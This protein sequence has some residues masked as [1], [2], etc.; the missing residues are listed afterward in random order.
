MDRIDRAVPRR[1]RPDAAEEANEPRN[2]RSRSTPPVGP[3]LQGSATP[4]Q[5]HLPIH[6]LQEVLPP[7]TAINRLEGSLRPRQAM[8]EPL[9]AN[10]SPLHG[11]ASAPGSAAR[12][13]GAVAHDLPTYT[14]RADQRILDLLPAYA[15]G[16]KI[17]LAIAS[18]GQYLTNDGLA[19]T[20]AADNWMGRLNADQRQAV[21]T[22]VESRKSICPVLSRLASITRDL[23]D[24]SRSLEQAARSAAV[25]LSSLRRVLTDAG[26]LTKFGERHIAGRKPNARRAIENNLI[27][28]ETRR[29]RMGEANQRSTAGGESSTRRPRV[30]PAAGERVVDHNPAREAVNPPAG[31]SAPSE[32]ATA[33]VS[34][35]LRASD[36]R[37]LDGLPAYANG[38]NIQ[39]KS[40]SMYLRNDGLANTPAATQWMDRLDEERQ[41]TV[42][43]AIE[44]RRSIRQVLSCLR[45]ITRDLSDP[46][47]S[48]EQAARRNGADPSNLRRVLTES[49][50]TELGQRHLSGRPMAQKSMQTNLDRRDWRARKMVG[51][52]R[53]GSTARDEASTSSPDLGETTLAASG[54]DVNAIASATTPPSPWFF[55]GLSQWNVGDHTPDAEGPEVTSEF[56]DDA[57]SRAGI[58]EVG[59]PTGHLRSTV[60]DAFRVPV[61]GPSAAPP[62][63]AD[64]GAAWQYL[65]GANERHEASRASSA[66]PLVWRPV[67]AARLLPR[68]ARDDAGAR[69]QFSA[70]LGI[71]PPASP[72]WLAETPRA[73]NTMVAEPWLAGSPD[74]S[75]FDSL[76]AAHFDAAQAHADP[77]F[78]SSPFEWGLSSPIS[79][80]PHQA[81]APGQ[82]GAGPTEHTPT[83]T[84]ASAGLN[85]GVVARAHPGAAN[86]IFD[87]LAAYAGGEDM[88]RLRER[89]PSFSLI[90]SNDGLVNSIQGAE[91]MRGLDQQQQKAVREAMEQRKSIR[92][93]VSSLSSMTHDLVENSCTLEQAAQRAGVDPMSAR[94]VLT[95]T[96]DLTALGRQRLSGLAP[97]VQRTIQSNLNFIRDSQEFQMRR[98]PAAR[99]LQAQRQDLEAAIAAMRQHRLSREASEQA[100]GLPAGVLATVVD[101]QGY[102]LTEPAQS[103]AV[104][105]LLPAQVQAFAT[106]LQ[107]M[108]ANLQQFEPVEQSP[109]RTPP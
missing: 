41:R 27:D 64:A 6:P 5:P 68:H 21:H 19:K 37:I 42:L 51:T 75:E 83:S 25:D 39:D 50:F 72:A 31:E 86:G 84:S 94:R 88:Q 55:E 74:F 49:G 1:P 90:F 80:L 48:F 28:R 70:R 78:D 44:D 95:E 7:R 33:S 93:V 109:V 32:R 20:R 59:H 57:P 22:A 8:P 77:N 26:Q 10:A 103:D 89:N 29:R 12:R 85:V 36:Q 102:W 79:G 98:M 65:S 66:T 3:R 92:Q 101:A 54:A 14:Q 9:P 17:E 2:V 69:P 47:V 106:K 38:E 105:G 11:L 16:E 58:E 62:S 97:R 34:R 23:A 96:G 4:H 46:A 43:K 91:F 76:L 52:G 24:P 73:K 56:P 104:A 18:V 53:G 100:V 71:S 15:D 61:D 108:R 60:A 67:D 13:P 107:L 87:L 30:A 99:M 63:Q 45:S 81:A 82:I 40:F 35:P